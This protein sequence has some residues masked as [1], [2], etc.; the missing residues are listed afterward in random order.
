MHKELRR[1]LIEKLFWPDNKLTKAETDWTGTGYSPSI[2]H[3][4]RS[5]HTGSLHIATDCQSV[6]DMHAI[7]NLLMMLMTLIYTVFRGFV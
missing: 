6:C 3:S 2:L 5:T 1:K 7:V 4:H